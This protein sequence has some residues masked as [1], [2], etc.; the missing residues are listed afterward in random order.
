MLQSDDKYAT[1]TA[2]LARLTLM[3]RDPAWVIL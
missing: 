2:V 3:Y 1:I